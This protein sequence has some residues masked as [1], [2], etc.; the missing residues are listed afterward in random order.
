MYCLGS[1]LQ[2]EVVQAQKLGLARGWADVVND[3]PTGADHPFVFSNCACLQPFRPQIALGSCTVYTSSRQT[4]RAASAI[5]VRA[6][7]PDAACNGFERGHEVRFV[8]LFAEDG[9]GQLCNNVGS[10]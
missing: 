3:M 8:A 9:S 1:N 7:S 6:V 2:P 4:S 10:G 5:A